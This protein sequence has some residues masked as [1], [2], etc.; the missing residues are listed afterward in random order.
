[1]SSSSHVLEKLCVL[2]MVAALALLF[3][4]MALLSPS[5]LQSMRRHHLTVVSDFIASSLVDDLLLDIEKLREQPSVDALEAP[6]ASNGA[7]EWFELL[8]H[9]PAA[10]TAAREALYN[11]VGGLQD[12]LESLDG[13]TLDAHCTVRSS[14]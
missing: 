5:A 13:I 2:S 8:P 1:M 3:E 12:S 6:S 4:S 9:R 11:L 10:P 7:V 14:R